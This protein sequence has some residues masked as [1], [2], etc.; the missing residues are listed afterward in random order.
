MINNINLNVLLD[1]AMHALCG[2]L[3]TYVLGVQACL[4]DYRLGVLA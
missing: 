3:G 2:A 4:R 1:S